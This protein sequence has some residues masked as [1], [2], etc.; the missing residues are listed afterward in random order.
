MSEAALDVFAE[1]SHKTVFQQV[2]V[3]ETQPAKHRHGETKDPRRKKSVEDE[4]SH[5][6]YLNI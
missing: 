4:D 1:V 6:T 5:W 3:N 2:E